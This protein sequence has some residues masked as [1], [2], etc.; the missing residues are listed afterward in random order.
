MQQQIG[1]SSPPALRIIQDLAL[2]RVAPSISLIAGYDLGLAGPPLEDHGVEQ[3]E[4]AESHPPIAC[5][6]LAEKPISPL[7]MQ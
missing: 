2:A 3:F 1:R 7:G 6:F 5:R 4:T